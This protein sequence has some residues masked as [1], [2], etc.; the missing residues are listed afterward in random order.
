VVLVWPVAVLVRRGILVAVEQEVPVAEPSVAETAAD[1]SI[2]LAVTVAA[3]VA[4]VAVVA[5]S[6]TL[7]AVLPTQPAMAIK[8]FV[9][10]ETARTRTCM[11]S[12]WACC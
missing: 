7:A 12:C 3:I 5:A 2:L 9:I 1:A 10:L 6:S 4:V 11:A 8:I